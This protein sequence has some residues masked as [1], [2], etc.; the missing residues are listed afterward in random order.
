[1]KSLKKVIMFM[2]CIPSLTY[3]FCYSSMRWWES[4]LTF[5]CVASY[6]FYEYY[7]GIKHERKRR[8]KMLV[9]YFD[10]DLPP[11]L[12]ARIEKMYMKE[13]EIDRKF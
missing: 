10:D 1:M 4:I 2:L 13:Y 12:A 7:R 5:I 8:V 11:Q 9:S 3:I 6:G